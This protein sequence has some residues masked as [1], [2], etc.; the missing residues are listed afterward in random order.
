MRDGTLELL[1]AVAAPDGSR[2]LFERASGP[3]DEPEALARLVAQR[4]AM[5]G[6]A[7]LPSSDTAE[8][9]L[10]QGNQEATG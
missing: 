9:G 8:T 2:V 7:N 1:A 5:R 4:L 10:V 6:A 3:L